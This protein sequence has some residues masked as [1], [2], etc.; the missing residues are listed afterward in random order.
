M[1]NRIHVEK[2][3]IARAVIKRRGIK[4]E[5][6]VV[7]RNRKEGK[8]LGLTNKNLPACALK[9]GWREYRKAS[10]GR[11]RLNSCVFELTEG[12]VNLSRISN[13]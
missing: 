3:S 8:T 2:L 1:E 9:N 11:V 12:N 5:E 4:R 13:F 6:L 7:E 10:L